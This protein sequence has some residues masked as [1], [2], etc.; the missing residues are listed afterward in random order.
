MKELWRGNCKLKH[1]F[2][3][4]ASVIKAR[5]QAGGELVHGIL[6]NQDVCFNAGRW[7]GL[8]YMDHDGRTWESEFSPNLSK[9]SFPLLKIVVESDRTWDMAVV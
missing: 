4:I 2:R 8:N 9:V 6:D 1:W 7:L 5:D 3:M